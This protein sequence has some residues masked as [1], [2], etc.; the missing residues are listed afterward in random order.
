MSSQARRAHDRSQADERWS[1]SLREEL[2]QA[3][4]ELKGVLAEVPLSLRRLL[5]LQAGDLI[6][7]DLPDEVTL[8]VEEVPSFRGE[9]GSH[10]GQL[11]VKI[12]KRIA[13]RPA[14]NLS[15]A[16]TP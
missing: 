3:P 1:E 7:M 14:R 9:L 2:Q 12:A 15:T 6:P 5:T 11:A 16:T 8:C 10:G 4:V 13:R